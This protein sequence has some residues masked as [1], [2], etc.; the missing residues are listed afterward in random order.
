[1]GRAAAA[2]F[3]VLLI[4]GAGS[5]QAARILII[6]QPPSGGII[7]QGG[8][9]FY[10][11]YWNVSLDVGYDLHIGDGFTVYAAPA[12]YTNSV[13]YQPDSNGPYVPE[14]D[15][16]KKSVDPLADTVA[17][18]G[19]NHEDVFQSN[20][21]WTLTGHGPGSPLENCPADGDP[22]PMPLNLGTFGYQTYADLSP[23][24]PGT[25]FTF[26]YTVQAHDC[27][28]NAVTGEGTFTLTYVPEPSSV[29]L[30]A[31]GGAVPFLA[32]FRRRAAA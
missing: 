31:L 29:A 3:A 1:M 2:L 15:F 5:A 10:G 30:L 22:N 8:D 9:P 32:A 7:P 28:G 19:A 24:S 27:D 20:I 18:P 26:F 17:W 14:G 16:W 23:L 13:V 4:G 25:Q 6:T 12:L 11:L 21:S